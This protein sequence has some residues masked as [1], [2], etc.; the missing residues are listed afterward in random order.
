[1]NNNKSKYGKDII[2]ITVIVLLACISIVCLILFLINGETIMSHEPDEDAV[3]DRLSCESNKVAY[4]LFDSSG[5]IDKNLRIN[6]TFN[7]KALDSISIIYRLDYNSEEEIINSE[8]INHAKINLSFQESGLT[9]D[10]LSA[11]YGKLEKS[12][13]FSLY[14]KG[15]DLNSKTLRYFMLDKLNDKSYTSERVAELYN[16]LGLNC[17]LTKQQD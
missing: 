6:A 11:T 1:M 10:Y 7:R 2:M 12:L 14:G 16:K 5:A 3:V 17:E 9:A 8:A 15:D 4:P 13:Q